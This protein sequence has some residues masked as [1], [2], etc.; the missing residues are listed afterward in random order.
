MGDCMGVSDY[1]FDEIKRW[2]HGEFDTDFFLMMGILRIRI[3]LICMSR[4]SVVML[5]S[6]K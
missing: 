6:L 1:S 3:S 4:V 2:S 5:G